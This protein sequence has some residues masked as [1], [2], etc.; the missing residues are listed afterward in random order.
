MFLCLYRT[1]SRS[2][3]SCNSKTAIK[4]FGNT[5]GALPTK[6]KHLLKP[7]SVKCI[8]FSITVFASF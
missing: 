8:G 7:P 1:F 5:T 6:D 2:K 3:Q 4:V